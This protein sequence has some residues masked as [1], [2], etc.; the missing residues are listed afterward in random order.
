[1]SAD[2]SCCA[3]LAPADPAKDVQIG[4]QHE[5][6]LRHGGPGAGPV[7]VRALLRPGRLEGGS[8][9]P[10]RRY[11]EAVKTFQPY[12]RVQ[13]PQPDVRSD[14]L[15]VIGDYPG[16]I[17]IIVNNR[18]EGNAPGTIDALLAALSSGNSIGS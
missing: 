16:E 2:F 11:E 3:R 6:V 5:Q 15:T 1:M 10:G 18:L 7:L 9:R 17:R 8:V 4:W 14:I 12:D 13:Q